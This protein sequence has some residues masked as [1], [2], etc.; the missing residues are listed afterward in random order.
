MHTTRK[1]LGQV[2]RALFA[3][4]LL[5]GFA[6][7]LQLALPFYALHVFESALP[8]ASLETVGLL[9]LIAAGA[10]L[11]LVSLV[12]A[13]DRIVLRAGLWLDHTLGRHILE[14]GTRLGTPPAEIAANVAALARY[15]SALSDR[16]IVAMLDAPWLPLLLAAMALLHPIMGA[17]AGVSALLLVLATLAQARPVGRFAQQAAEASERS[18]RWWSASTANGD[19]QPEAADQWERLNRT[20]IANAYAL[21]KRSAI[22]QDLA[23]LVRVGAQV[24]LIAVGAWLVL[25]NALTPAALFACILVN[26]ALLEPLERLVAALPVVRAAAAAHRRLRALPADA[27]TAMSDATDPIFVSSEPDMAPKPRRL[28]ISGPLAAGLAAAVLFIAAGLGA[29]HARLGDLAG[30][31]GGAI[32]ET[33]LTPLHYPKVGAGARVHVK[34]GADVKAGD[35]I[36]TRDTAALDQQ[37]VR[38]KA[39]AEATRAQPGA[40]RPGNFG[41]DEPQR[42]GRP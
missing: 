27:E 32:F 33:K 20:H 41:D 9:A 19:L 5:A 36:I 24:A 18:A 34:E 25:T 22:L 3:A 26:A 23:R 6:N 37:I 13:R 35:V 4:L 42:A 38:L 1:L 14:N 7:L 12:A 39:L 10:G 16:S 21:G 17:V 30:L 2:R 28:N 11:T 8:A 31:A 15:T 29:A 40:D